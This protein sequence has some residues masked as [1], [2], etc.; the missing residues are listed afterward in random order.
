MTAVSPAAVVASWKALF[1]KLL[2]PAGTVMKRMVWMHRCGEGPQTWFFLRPS[3]V[4]CLHP[5]EQK[6]YP[7]FKWESLLFLFFLIA[8]FPS[9]LWFSQ[10]SANH[11]HPWAS[12]GLKTQ[13][14]C[15]GQIQLWLK[16]HVS[17]DTATSF[18]PGLNAAIIV[19]RWWIG[20]T[21]LWQC[22]LCFGRWITLSI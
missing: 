10:T 21:M 5:T 11:P 9:L 3:C 2:M 20:D 17:N 4:Q 22:R 16:L 1:L 15:V 7:V 12:F 13:K 8:P 19:W 18:T 6:P 14:L